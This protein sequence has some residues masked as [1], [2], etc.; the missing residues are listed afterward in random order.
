M[1]FLYNAGI[2]LYTLLIRLA[3]LFNPKARLWVQGRKQI[4][5]KIKQN[6]PANAPVAWFHCAS[7]GEFE[8]GRPLIEAFRQKFPNYKIVLT[9]FSPSGYEIRKNYAHA[10]AIFYLPPDTPRNA[11]RFVTLVQPGIVFFVKYEF[12]YNY[13]NTLKKAQIPLYSVSAIFR[14]SQVFFKPY[15]GWYRKTLACFS[16]FF[17]QNSQSAK[18]LKNIGF[19]NSQICGD[20]RFD[21]VFSIARQAAP[22]PLVE[23]FANNAPVLVAG[24]TWHDDETLLIPLINSF[25]G[26]WKFIIAPHEVNENHIKQIENQITKNN[27]RFS[28]ASE[29]KVANSQV[30]IIDSIGLLS[31]IYRYGTIAYIGGGFG[32]GIHNILEAATFGLPVIFG[33]N[34]HKFQEAKDLIAE[35][36]AFSVSGKAEIEKIWKKLLEEPDFL[37]KS[38]QIAQNYV[39]KKRGGT[40]KILHYI[41]KIM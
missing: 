16:F 13:L 2:F 9:F 22:V 38:S 7:L 11:R 14:P 26:N 36:G 3:A 23:A 5:E 41:K 33:T 8:Q 32:A 35:G 39:E 24:S 15:G 31:A 12:W 29:K 1:T 37:Q 4:F 21:R 18:L 28:L 19:E 34:Y 6:L 10:D 30:L 20:T 17:V 25:S 27:L 40:E